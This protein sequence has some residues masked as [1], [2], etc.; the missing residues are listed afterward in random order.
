MTGSALL[1][2][3]HLWRP[4]ELRTSR[5]WYKTA[6]PTL[7][8]E[9]QQI[10][11]W[12]AGNL[13]AITP[14]AIRHFPT[15][16][17]DTLATWIRKQIGDE[18]YGVAKL[19]GLPTDPHYLAASTL[20]L[21]ASMGTILDNYGKLY[22]VYDR[23]GCY[24]TEAIPISQTRHPTGFHTDSARRE[25]IPDVI[26][27]TCVRDGIGGDTQLTSATHVYHRLVT[28]KPELVS[29]LHQSYVRAVVTPGTN[30]TPEALAANNFPVFALSPCGEALTFRYM[31]YWIEQGQHLAGAPIDRKTT[32]A[33]DWLDATLASP[34]C[35]HEQHLHPGDLLWVANRD[36][37]HARTNYENRP[38]TT[39]LFYRMWLSL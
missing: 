19:Q 33:L 35:F 10:V 24:K 3:R 26:S 14:E 34:A 4:D 38:G 20:I 32:E 27:L 31:R 22:D 29:S 11:T 9:L 17:I 25:T 2:S 15:P 1:P 5:T 12:S 7:I 21:G 8:D 37:A 39:R 36:V 6:S 30:P 16:A 28:E 18:G 23:G 13:D